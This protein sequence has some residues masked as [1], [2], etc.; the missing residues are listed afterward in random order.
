[1]WALAAAAALTYGLLRAAVAEP[2]RKR[3]ALERRLTTLANNLPGQLSLDQS[4]DGV[5]LARRLGRKDLEQQFR[6]RVSVLKQHRS[7][8]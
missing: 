3:R 4:E 5:F 1:M 7:I 6:L 2:T 8:K